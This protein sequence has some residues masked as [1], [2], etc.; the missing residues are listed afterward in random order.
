MAHEI[1][2]GVPYRM[3]VLAPSPETL[4]NLGI[5]RRA[6]S[7]RTGPSS[8]AGCSAMLNQEQMGIQNI[9]RID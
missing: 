2:F 6:R 7:V 3:I 1:Q 9:A 4:T 8:V 5:V